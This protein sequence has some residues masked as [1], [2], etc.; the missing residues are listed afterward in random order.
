MSKRAM[1][2]ALSVMMGITSAA[3]L[4]MSVMAE[5]K[6]YTTKE[7]HVAIW[8]NNQLDG[9]QQIADEWTEKSGVPGQI[10]VITWNEYW[11]LLEAGAS[12]G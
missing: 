10:D 11:T 12:G 1:A 4:P 5:E 8:D 3:A 9:L 7:I 2:A 6:E